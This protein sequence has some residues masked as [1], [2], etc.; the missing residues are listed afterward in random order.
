[1]VGSCVALAGAVDDVRVVI[2]FLG[3]GPACIVTEEERS[4]KFFSWKY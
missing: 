3:L 1:M 4:K 2:S